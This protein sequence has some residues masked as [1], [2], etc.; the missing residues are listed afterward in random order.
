MTKTALVIDGDILLWECA[1]AVEEPV[2]WGDDLWTLHADAAQA[3]IHLDVAFARLKD[4]LNATNIGVAFSSSEN[5]RKS[6]LTTYKH[7]RKKTRKPVVFHALKEYARSTYKCIEVPTLEADD[8]CGV[9]LTADNSSFYRTTAD[10][11][12]LVSS[13]KD[14]LQ[15]PGLHYNP[16]KPEDEIFEVT[17]DQAHYNHMFQ[18]LTG[19][20]VDGYGGC[21]KVGPKTAAKI[22][23][24]VAPQD[25]WSVVVEAYAKTGHTEEEALVQARVARILHKSDYNFGKREVRLWT[26]KK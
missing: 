21:P 2:D 5:W 24:G 18:T 9:I 22:L 23:D 1:L 12:I 6:V 15:I 11:K 19:D 20:T 3:K 4:K 10:E 16:N 14:L 26:P 8:I 25:R 13:D 17:P 7:N